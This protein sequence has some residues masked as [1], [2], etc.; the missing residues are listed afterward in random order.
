VN[1]GRLEVLEILLAVLLP[2]EF[3][4]RDSAKWDGTHENV[5]FNARPDPDPNTVFPS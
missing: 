4:L 1:R 2:N 3:K 5:M